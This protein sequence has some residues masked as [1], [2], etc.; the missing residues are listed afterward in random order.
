MVLL[1]EQL[2]CKR[3]GI[4]KDGECMTEAAIAKFVAMFQLKLPALAVDALRALFRLDCDLAAAVEDA[5]LAHGCAAAVELAHDATGLEDDD[6][7][8]PTG[9]AGQQIVT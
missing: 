9:A 5:L 1:A 4:L 2:L 3:L 7:V 6:G 8:A